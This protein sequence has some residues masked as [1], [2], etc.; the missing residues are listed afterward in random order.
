VGGEGGRR[1]G[2]GG[3]TGGEAAHVPRLRRPRMRELLFE[4]QS[5]R[6]LCQ[7]GRDPDPTERKTPGLA[8]LVGM[9]RVLQ[10]LLED[11]VALNGN[12][13]DRNDRR[14]SERHLSIYRFCNR[15]HTSGTSM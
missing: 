10:V 12:R 13:D 1:R 14:N 8:V 3:G 5:R 7:C 11:D 9:P 4:F 15:S 2:R 6:R